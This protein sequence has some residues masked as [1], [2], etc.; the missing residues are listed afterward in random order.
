MRRS[1]LDMLAVSRA[2]LPLDPKARHIIDVDV[3]VALV[4][5]DLVGIAEDGCDFL[6]R[7]ALGIGEEE[8]HDDSADRPGDDEAEVE[9]PA[10]GSEA[11]TL[12][13]LRA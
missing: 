6:E 9:F 10:N 5:G 4:D 3:D 12:V 2:H 11:Q 1:P 7:H 13:W 8:P